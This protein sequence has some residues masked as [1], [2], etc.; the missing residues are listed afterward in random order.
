MISIVK[1]LVTEGLYD[2]LNT[3]LVNSKFGKAVD[4]ANDKIDSKLQKSSLG[5]KY[6]NVENTVGNAAKQGAN[7]IYNFHNSMLMRNFKRR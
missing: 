1:A 6:M 3:K 4:K 7:A 2:T 5:R